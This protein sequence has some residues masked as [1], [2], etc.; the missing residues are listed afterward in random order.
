MIAIYPG[1]FDPPTIG[2]LDIIRR[3]AALCDELHVCVMMNYE[4]RYQL[5][6]EER[7]RLLTECAKRW[8]NVIVCEKEG[9][10]LDVC[11][12]LGAQTVIRGLRGEGDYA[13][14]RPVADAFLKLGG[15]ETVFIQSDPTHAYVSSSLVR[16]LMAFGGDI[17]TLVPEPV[18]RALTAQKEDK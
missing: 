5:S 8:P 16:E 13:K 11:S 10:L 4:K 12:R 17:Q 7:V 2:H 18:F 1:S 14:E 3:A 9:L 15:V 6:A